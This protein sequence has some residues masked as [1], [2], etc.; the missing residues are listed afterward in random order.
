H[1]G[2]LFSCDH[3][4]EPN[5]LLGNIEEIPLIEMVGSAR[6]QEFGTHKRD[7]LPNYCLECEVRFVCNG[8]C[9]KNRFINTPDGEPGLNYL[10]AGYR[11]FFNHVRPYMNFMADQLR[12]QQAPA[13]IM[14]YLA[15]ED[16]KLNA[17]FA[18]AKRNDPCPCGSGRKFKQC[19]GRGRTVERAQMRW[20]VSS[21]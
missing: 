2:D 21:N 10:C 16:R 14:Q 6:Q 7:S 8:G 3:Y 5:Y 4:V 13:N 20:P 15:E 17:R 12:R 11:A 18:G 19:H 1:N 9:P